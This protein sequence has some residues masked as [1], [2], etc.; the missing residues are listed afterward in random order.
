MLHLTPRKGA[1]IGH[2]QPRDGETLKLTP[3]ALQEASS[4][5]K[6]MA[7][8]S[9]LTILYRLRDGEKSVL[10]LCKSLE[11][12]QPT[13]SQHLARLREE[14]MVRTRREGQAIY[15]SLASDKVRRIIDLVEEVSA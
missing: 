7:N 11:L 9:R 1:N 13:V 2:S 14:G 4:L 12:R 8:V 5:L 15:Y 3:E 6:A 10:E